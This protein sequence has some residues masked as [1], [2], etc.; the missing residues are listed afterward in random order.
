MLCSM[1]THPNLPADLV[2]RAALH[3]DLPLLLL[4]LLSNI[5]VSLC[6]RFQLSNQGSRF[7]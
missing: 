4:L 2:G 7:P 5:A 1:T 6:G 3:A